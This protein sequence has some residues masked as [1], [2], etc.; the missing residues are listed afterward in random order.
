[1]V[2]SETIGA[3]MAGRVVVGLAVGIASM[4]TPVY[5]SEL[6][7]VRVRGRVVALSQNG[8]IKT[9]QGHYHQLKVSKITENGIMPI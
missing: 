8:E 2:F 3:L 5:I 4:I 1:M 6:S 7:P 9:L